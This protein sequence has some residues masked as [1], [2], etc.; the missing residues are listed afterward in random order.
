MKKLL[1]KIEERENKLESFLNS[2]K[3][4]DFKKL[5][6]D[7]SAFITYKVEKTIDG[8]KRR[9]TVIV[10]KGNH[11]KN[12][13]HFHT[14]NDYKELVETLKNQSK[15]NQNLNKVFGKYYKA[16]EMF[17]WFMDPAND[18]LWFPGNINS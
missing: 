1:E 16:S 5:I 9:L 6:S 7:E 10:L 14:V 18:L 11:Q 17:K 13:Y 15:G 2:N 4:F 12:E 8:E 3:E